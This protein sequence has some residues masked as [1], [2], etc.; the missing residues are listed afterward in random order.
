MTGKRLLGNALSLRRTASR[1]YRLPE[2]DLFGVA[3]LLIG[4]KLKKLDAERT[5]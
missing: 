4:M 3:R 5:S 2:V 1:L